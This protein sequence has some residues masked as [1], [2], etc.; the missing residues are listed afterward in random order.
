MKISKKNDN[1]NLFDLF[2]PLAETSATFTWSEKGLRMAPRAVGVEFDFFWVFRRENGWAYFGIDSVLRSQRIQK[3]RTGP[4]T[5]RNLRPGMVRR[6]IGI[7]KKKNG[8]LCSSVF[9]DLWENT[10]SWLAKINRWSKMSVEKNCV[11]NSSLISSAN[12]YRTGALWH[13]CNWLSLRQ[14]SGKANIVL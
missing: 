6:K 8:K 3:R 1:L 10:A 11:E 4:A 7:P 9:L 14:S 5:L 12:L 2:K 13:H